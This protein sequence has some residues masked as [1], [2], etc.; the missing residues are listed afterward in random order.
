MKDTLNWPVAVGSIARTK[1]QRL[2]S[3]LTLAH[4]STGSAMVPVRLRDMPRE[5]KATKEVKM[6]TTTAPIPCEDMTCGCMD[7]KVW[8]E[9]IRMPFRKCYGEYT[10]CPRCRKAHY[11]RARFNVVMKER[12]QG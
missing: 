11:D 9:S 2:A 5:A 6:T 8:E 7:C 10:S 3:Q 12:M 4:G 1:E